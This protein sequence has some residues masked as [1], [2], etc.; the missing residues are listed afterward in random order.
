MAEAGIAEAAAPADPADGSAERALARYYDL[1]LSVEP[2]DLPLY[3]ALA[4]RTG[5]PVLELAVG[6]GRLAV[7]LASAGWE[8]IGVDRDP[9][10]LARAHDRWRAV[11]GDRAAR[12]ELVTADLVEVELRR[13]FALVVL[14]L[15]SL[16]LLGSGDLQAGALRTMARHLRPGGL[17][18][19]DVW[20]PG[21][22]DLALYD[23]RLLLEWIRDDQETGERVA[24]MTSAVHD[25]ATATVD[26]EAIFDAWPPGGGAVRRVARRDRLRLVSGDELVRRAE[27]AGLAVD[28][29][30][31]DYA[32]TPFG[33]GAERAV[34]LATLV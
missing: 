28:L 6:T 29:L 14:A 34:L 9:H 4:Q 23:G 10:M 25:A 3:V 24:K 19:V 27:D 13:S 16:L 32:L 22:D 12:L 31:A 21:P 2:G 5:G 11:D 8:V 7:P 20:L 15:N 33:P 26:L 18:V 30:A 17:A 1:D